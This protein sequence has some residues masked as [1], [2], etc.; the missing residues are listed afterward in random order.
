MPN[1]PVVMFGPGCSHDRYVPVGDSCQR[2]PQKGQM[3]HIARFCHVSSCTN[4]SS[5]HFGAW[6]GSSKRSL[7]AESWFSA[8]AQTPS[9]FGS[10][11]N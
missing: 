2:Q 11:V 6:N 8:A 4:M 3:T 1:V 9:E 7:S 5:S 10:F